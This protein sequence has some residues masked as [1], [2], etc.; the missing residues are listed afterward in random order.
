MLFVSE[1]SAKPLCDILER[2]K[3]R[4]VDFMVEGNNQVSFCL[5]ADMGEMKEL[6]LLRYDM[7]HDLKYLVACPIIDSTSFHLLARRYKPRL[8]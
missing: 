1:S 4:D 8:H 6:G 5:G 7:M 2:V 3:M